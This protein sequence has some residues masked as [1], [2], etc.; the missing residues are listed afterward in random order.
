MDFY[1]KIGYISSQKLKKKSTNVCFGLHVY[2]RTNKTIH[3]TLCVFDNRRNNLSYQKMQ[4]NYSKKLFTRRTKPIRITSIIQWSSTAPCV[5]PILFKGLFF[6]V[7][8]VGYLLHFRISN[9]LLE[10]I[11]FVSFTFCYSLYIIQHTKYY[12]NTKPKFG[13]AYS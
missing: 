9:S 10:L 13:E 1:L 3:N 2:L 6:E 4:Y 5:L 8:H 7:T 12:V 11:Q